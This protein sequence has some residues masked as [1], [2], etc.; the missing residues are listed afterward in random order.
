MLRPSVKAVDGAR[1]EEESMEKSWEGNEMDAM[2]EEFRRKFEPTEQHVQTI[3]NF[4]RR[5]D[6]LFQHLRERIPPSKNPEFLQELYGG[7]DVNAVVAS[8]QM[9]EADYEA[10]FKKKLPE[11]QVRPT[12]GATGGRGKDTQASSNARIKSSSWLNG[13][14]WAHNMVADFV[15]ENKEFGCFDWENATLE[16][17]D[18]FVG[19][20]WVWMGPKEGGGSL[21][22]TRYTTDSLKQIK[23]K[24][25][26]VIT[27]MM[28]RKDVDLT[29]ISMTFSNNMY[30]AKRNS[31][32][33]EPMSGNAGDRK[34][35]A[36]SREDSVKMDDWML[37]DLNQVVAE[38]CIM[39]KCNAFSFTQVSP[40][41]LQLK[42]GAILLQATVARGSDCVEQI[43]RSYV[44]I[45]VGKEGNKMA[46]IRG[47]VKKKTMQGRSSNF[48]PMN[49]T[50]TGKEEVET[51]EKLL[52]IVAKKLHRICSNLLKNH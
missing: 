21:G 40:L 14:I 15:K 20:L 43:R 10:K 34:R 50:I 17:I 19:Y 45:E 12:M 52:H 5:K 37:S 51:I 25:Q 1:A 47:N 9:T 36:L 26:N 24:I 8:F 41:D 48:E 29:S 4:P 18:I 38:I 46:K 13:M 31:T 30:N 44:S 27:N 23:T 16:D 7:N 28:K 49:V 3:K 6:E 39:Y 42:V 33:I 11:I 32:G 35:T 2:L 22:G